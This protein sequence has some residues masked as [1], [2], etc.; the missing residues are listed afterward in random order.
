MLTNATFDDNQFKSMEETN[1]FGF[2]EG[3]T[4]CTISPYFK[5]HEGKEKEWKDNAKRF[6]ERTRTENDVIHF[7]FSYTDDGLVHCRE[8]Y[9]SGSA[10]LFHQKNVDGPL[11]SALKF[12]SLTRLEFHGPKS[13]IEIV[14][15]ALTPLGCIFFTADKASI[16]NKRFYKS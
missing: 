15:E 13:E 7:G 8:A 4:T 3:D 6:Y 16:K 9:K 5:I 1:T 11:N 14:R 2:I 12:A 10:L